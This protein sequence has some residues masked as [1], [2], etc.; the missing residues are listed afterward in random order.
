MNAINIKFL[1]DIKLVLYEALFFVSY[2]FI[3]RF[4]K[5]LEVT[6]NCSGFSNFTINVMA[7]WRT[8]WA[9]TATLEL[10][11]LPPSKNFKSKFDL[12][13]LDDYKFEFPA[14]FWSK[15][16]SNYTA[17]A[18]SLVNPGKLNTLARLYGFQDLDLLS[19][20]CSD[21]KDGALIGCKGRFRN[22]SRATNAPSAYENGA[23]VTDAICDWLAKGFAF[24]PVELS[25][26]PATAKFS[27]IM[28]RPKPNGSVRII[29]NLSAPQ[30]SSV[31]E[32]IDNT[33][34]PTTMSS[35][36][37]WLRVLHLAGR[38][39]KMCKVDWSDAYK[40]VA[41]NLADTDLQWFQW[42]GKAFKE[43]CLIFGGVSSAG[44]FD[45]LAK[46]VLFIVIKKSGFR[47]DMVCQHL[48][49]CCAAAP[50]HSALLE[51]YDEVFAEVAE[52]LGVKLAPR[53]D[54]EKSFAPAQSGII[55]GIH[56]NTVEWTWALPQEKLLRL[57]HLIKQLYCA[58]SVEQH[59]IWTLV[60]KIQ[61]IK[62]LM[63][64]G[65]F[66]VDHLIRAN[67]I[68]TE[69][70]HPVCITPEMKR[71][72]WF[73]LTMLRLCSG[74]GPIPD[75]DAGL[76]PWA[77][78]VYTDAAG[79]S[80]DCDRGVGAVSD[81]WWTFLPW[82]RKINMGGRSRNGKELGRMMSALELIGPLIV[83]ASGYRWCSKNSVRIW[84]DNAGSVFIWQKGYSTSCL[85]SSSIVKAIAT[86]AAGIGCQVEL[87]K[88]TRCST[89]LADMADALSKCA[90]PRFWEQ[91]KANSYQHNCAPAWI[92]SS[93]VAWVQDP[94]PDDGLGQKILHDLSRR[95]AVLGYNC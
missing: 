74:R 8:L 67:S 15:V 50:L 64:A 86:V 47:S 33:E 44:I 18:I 68:S 40:H 72:L 36:T 1:F 6:V 94:V 90:F 41:V 54:P 80:K 39:A 24:G 78:D 89:P 57:L 22:P 31:N 20:I 84:V 28:T 62:A 70:S 59:L 23:Q 87:V 25:E 76:P 3:T 26:V 34:F 55:L 10:P 27:G 91:S 11:D 77:I 30:G 14:W 82:S 16:P 4:N 38:G 66:N 13:V 42:G 46:V 53:V 79:G 32:G 37:K 21:L 92:P 85:L 69:R 58:S 19:K 60:G 63:P 7:R 9:E 48:D 45:R 5:I 93:L 49:D 61:H 29:L 95:T 83:V 35:T 2:W 43:L 73:W 71:Q 81:S 52:Y 65:R 88:I 17:P 75:P 56:Y 12:P 51:K